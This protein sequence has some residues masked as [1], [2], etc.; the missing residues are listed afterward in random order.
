MDLRIPLYLILSLLAFAANSVLCRLALGHGYIDPI[1]FTSIRLISGA[2]ALGAVLWFANRKTNSSGASRGSWLG[3][4]CL[5]VYVS[6]MFLLQP[7]MFID[8]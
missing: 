4:I 1:S 7:V 6:F 2:I 3:A 5:F 8:D